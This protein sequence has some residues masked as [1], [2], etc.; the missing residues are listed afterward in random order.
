MNEDGF[1]DPEV[2][3]A[4]SFSCDKEPRKLLDAVSAE[5]GKLGGNKLFL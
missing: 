4:L 1:A 2:H 3:L 5:W